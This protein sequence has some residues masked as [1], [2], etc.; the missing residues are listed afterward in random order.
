MGHCQNWSGI[1]QLMS[2]LKARSISDIPN[3]IFIIELKV[4]NLFLVIFGDFFFPESFL[5]SFPFPKAHQNIS[6]MQTLFF[7]PKCLIFKIFKCKIRSKE[8]SSFGRQR[9]WKC[10]EY[11]V[12]FHKTL[13][14]SHEGFWYSA[15]ENQHTLSYNLVMCAYH[16]VRS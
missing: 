13:C 8:S 1:V 5:I 14:F 3:F 16:S 11:P 6:K 9:T 10:L 15:L 2:R 12:S 7:C 4:R